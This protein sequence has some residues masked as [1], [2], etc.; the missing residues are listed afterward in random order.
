MRPASSPLSVR[1]EGGEQGEGQ[2]KGCVQG[3]G[4]VVGKIG[5]RLRP[6]HPRM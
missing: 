4:T 1:Q 5:G 3:V 6:K 2:D